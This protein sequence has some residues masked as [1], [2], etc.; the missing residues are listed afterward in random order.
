MRIVTL[1]F[2]LLVG[3]ALTAQAPPPASARLECGSSFTAFTKTTLTFGRERSLRRQR[4]TVSEREW[5]AFLRDQVTPRFPSGFG[6]FEE[7]GQ[8]RMADGRIVREKG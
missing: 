2:L 3:G 1:S 8:Y 4:G 6:T 5:Q 7:S